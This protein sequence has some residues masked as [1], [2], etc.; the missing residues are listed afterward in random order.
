MGIMRLIRAIMGTIAG[1]LGIASKNL[2]KNPAAMEAEFESIEAE[3]R[4][5]AA[6]V[7]D[8]IKGV[9]A[10]RMKA[11]A[12]LQDAVDEIKS[13]E[14]DLQGAIA[15][16]KERTEKVGV[17]K[18]ES[19]PEV[20][21]YMVLYNQAES[22]LKQKRER[23]GRLQTQA[24]NLQAAVDDYMLQLNVLLEDIDRLKSTRKQTIADVRMNQEMEK[25]L[26]VR[27][28][29]QTTG[30]D[31]RLARLLDIGREAA[32]GV[33]IAGKV[34]GADASLNRA[35]LKEAARKST[36]NADFL[37]QIGV[38]PKTANKP[39]EEAAAPATAEK[40]PE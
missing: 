31:E 9:E 4:A 40:L 30:A 12:E 38:A 1:I 35:K 10:T 26:R 8:S 13:L 19:D 27:A 11:V 17:D 39:A 34:N 20:Q 21:K 29:I 32:A 25:V 6:A 36:S 22:A 15:L 16:A 3:K 28:G 23:I 2:E 18:A 33:S 14:E 5:A 24:E 7:T 37:K